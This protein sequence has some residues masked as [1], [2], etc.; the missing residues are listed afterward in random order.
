MLSDVNPRVKTEVDAEDNITFCAEIC[1][2]LIA[3]LKKDDVLRVDTKCITKYESFST[4][5]TVRSVFSNLFM[6]IMQIMRV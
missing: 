2:E 5:A 6:Q 3:E 1:D 4:K